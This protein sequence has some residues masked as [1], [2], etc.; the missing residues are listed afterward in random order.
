MDL[1]IIDTGDYRDWRLFI[2]IGRIV[3]AMNTNEI[4]SGPSRN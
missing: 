3:D 1:V 2:G 4:G